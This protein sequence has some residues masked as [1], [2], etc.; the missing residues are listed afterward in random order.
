MLSSLWWAIYSNQHCQR[1]DNNNLTIAGRPGGKMEGQTVQRRSFEILN[2]NFDWR[3]TYKTIN[4]KTI[5]S[6]L[7]FKFKLSCDGHFLCFT[8]L[9]TGV[10]VDC[11][12]NYA[13]ND[14]FSPYTWSCQWYWCDQSDVHVND[15]GDCFCGYHGDDEGDHI[16]CQENPDDHKRVTKKRWPHNKLEHDDDIYVH[17]RTCCY[18]IRQLDRLMD[19]N[20]ITC[21]F[22]K[23]RSC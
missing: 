3:K 4:Y 5:S 8:P 9:N 11:H 10:L 18:M 16:N 6:F 12:V 20:W 19:N 15:D 2:F 22:T 21:S 14:N 17:T 23:G 13:N 7:R 1:L